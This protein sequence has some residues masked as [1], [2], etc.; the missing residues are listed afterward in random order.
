MEDFMNESMTWEMQLVNR[1]PIIF[2]GTS[3]FQKIET[4]F[5]IITE[6]LYQNG[7][8]VA[9]ETTFLKMYGP[10][11]NITRFKN[12]MLP[13]LSHLIYFSTVLYR[14]KETA[15]KHNP[16]TNLVIRSIPEYFLSKEMYR[17][18]IEDA[19]CMFWPSDIMDGIVHIDIWKNMGG[20]KNTIT[21][22]KKN[23]VPTLKIVVECNNLSDSILAIKQGAD[24]IVLTGLRA[25]TVSDVTKAIRERFKKAYI[26]YSGDVSLTNIEGFASSGVDSISIL[27]ITKLFGTTKLIPKVTE[28]VAPAEFE[29]IDA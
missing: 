15:K 26:E 20:I 13:V 21:F 2:T 7:D 10:A 9:N 19:G 22:L 28:Y 3:L 27:D 14:L 6:Y 23:V 17:D 8:F 18:A 1:G 4:D 25:E 5:G 24:G 11:G 16:N 12:E 29:D